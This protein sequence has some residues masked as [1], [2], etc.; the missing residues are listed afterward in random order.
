MEQNKSY[1]R[2]I[3][4]AKSF[5]IL[6]LVFLVCQHTTQMESLIG[7]IAQPVTAVFLTM[8]MGTLATGVSLL[9]D[10]QLQNLTHHLSRSLNPKG[11]F[12]Q[13]LVHQDQI[14]QNQNRDGL[15]RSRTQKRHLPPIRKSVSAPASPVTSAPSSPHPTARSAKYRSHSLSRSTEAL[16]LISA[17]QRSASTEPC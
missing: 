13:Y 9:R 8:V 14:R 11:W 2:L 1:H 5:G 15:T 6:L 17:L 3:N 7:V 4:K 12:D 10:R 16:Q